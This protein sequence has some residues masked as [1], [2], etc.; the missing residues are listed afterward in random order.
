MNYAERDPYD[1][2]RSSTEAMTEE[3]R[4]HLAEAIGARPSGKA[5]VKDKTDLEVIISDLNFEIGRLTKAHLSIENE[6]MRIRGSWPQNA[7]DVECAPDSDGDIAMLRALVSLLRRRINDIE[8]HAS[9]I[10]QI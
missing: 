6:L 7:D 10:A 4:R 9:R 3:G 1:P 2:H 8:D 5:S